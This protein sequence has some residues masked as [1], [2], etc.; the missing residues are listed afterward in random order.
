M[1]THAGQVIYDVLEQQV[2]QHPHYAGSRDGP[3]VYPAEEYER[4]TGMMGLSRD[5]TMPDGKDPKEEYLPLMRTEIQ[6]RTLGEYGKLAEA[7][8]GVSPDALAAADEALTQERGKLA[9]HIEELRKNGSLDE[10]EQMAWKGYSLKHRHTM[11]NG[12]QELAQTVQEQTGQALTMDDLAQAKQAK[13]GQLGKQMAECYG[14]LEERNPELSVL[15]PQIANDNQM[16][17][18][19]LGVLS[20][21][22]IAD[23]QRFS[24]DGITGIEANKDPAWRARQEEIVEKTGIRPQWIPAA[25]TQMRMLQQL[26]QQEAG[27][28]R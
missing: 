12:L 26:R 27:M 2:E 28:A 16:W 5:Y 1:K 6:N 3:W 20:K 10:V 23:V 18:V 14:R 7:A 9:E 8:G 15:T 13:E 11:L 17:G 22:N 4:Q 24:I 21:F 19:L 25:S